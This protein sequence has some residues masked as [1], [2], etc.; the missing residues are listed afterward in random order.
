MPNHAKAIEAAVS[1]YGYRP[2]NNYQRMQE[3]ITAFL[4]T[5]EP[6]PAMIE[7]GFDEC[8]ANWPCEECRAGLPDIHKAMSATLA[9]EVE[10]EK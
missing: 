4:R 5:V 3:A 8:F 1:A 7:A 6:S 2:G 10:A 9:D